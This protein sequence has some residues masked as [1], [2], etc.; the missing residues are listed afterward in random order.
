MDVLTINGDDRA[1]LLRIAEATGLFTM[2]DAEALL[3]DVVDRFT[4]GQLPEGHCVYACRCAPGQPLAGWTYVALDQHAA[5]VWNVWWLGVDPPSHG[6]GVGRALLHAAEAHATSH[7]ARLMVI[8][9]SSLPS[10]ARAR[11]FYAREGYAEC[12]RIPDFYGPG[13]A[14]VIFARPPT[15]SLHGTTL[16]DT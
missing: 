7:G 8:E 5:G 13:D 2:T 3:G 9:T 15:P 10:Q 6:T 4:G 14:K 16:R 1:A 11:R 12:G